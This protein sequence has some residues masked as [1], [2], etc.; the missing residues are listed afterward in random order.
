MTQDHER[1]ITY[2]IA[3][4]QEPAETIK[5][6]V[7]FIDQQELYS[8]F[9]IDSSWEKQAYNQ[10]EGI[11]ENFQRQGFVHAFGLRLKESLY[12]QLSLDH[13]EMIQGLVR[14]NISEHFIPLML[15]Q[16]AILFGMQPQRD[17]DANDQFFDN[18]RLA[19]ENEM[20]FAAVMDRLV[21]SLESFLEDA[22]QSY[23]LGA[24]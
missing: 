4:K 20:F 13:S 11:A 18:C 3:A 16:L 12:F 21:R 2:G 17:L 14:P 22:T 9:G 19:L 15:P 24:R 7:T 5:L 8:L 23:I 10:L 6:P 1:K